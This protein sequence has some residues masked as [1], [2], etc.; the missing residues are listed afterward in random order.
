MLLDLRTILVT[1]TLLG[2]LMALL[3]Y[4]QWQGVNKE[5]RGV[6][7]WA[8]A[9]MAFTLGQSLITLRNLLPEALVLF[10]SNLFLVL[11]MLAIL[12]GIG[13]FLGVKIPRS[14][15]F[16]VSAFLVVSFMISGH[17]V[18]ETRLGTSVFNGIFLI[19]SLICAVLLLRHKEKDLEANARAVAVTQLVF[20]VIAAF[21]LYGAL[22]FPWSGVWGRSALEA[23]LGILALTIDQ[24]AV[25]FTLIGLVDARLQTR[26]SRSA[27]E[28][29]L[30]VREMHHR[31]KNDF[32]LVESLISLETSEL[33]ECG[34]SEALLRVR[35]RIHSFALLHD[36]LYRGKTTGTVDTGEYLSLIAAGLVGSGSKDGRIRLRTQIAGVETDA[37]SAVSLGLIVNELITN[38][39]KHAFP[40]ERSGWIDLSLNLI[41]ENA[42]LKVKD[43]GVGLDGAEGEK[44]AE[45]LGMTLVSSLVAQIGGSMERTSVRGGGVCTSLYFPLPRGRT[46]HKRGAA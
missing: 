23:A 3:M 43:D 30:L 39:L 38:A 33:P 22:D 29:T 40:G 36:R 26:L 20:V 5:M 17:F 4:V 27:D 18:V 41:G 42:C 46:A 24:V 14:Y 16:V 12:Y 32:A 28:K 34:T 11:G 45:G 44:P 1:Q 6:G 35:D 7:L 2:L 19:N 21:R 37:G 25:A 31:T 13:A 10:P 15:G 8:I 9:F